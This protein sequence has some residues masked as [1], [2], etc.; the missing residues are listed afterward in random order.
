MEDGGWRM[1]NRDRRIE[2]EVKMMK[3]AKYEK[4]KA[5]SEIFEY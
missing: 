3:Q 4:R 5:K 2:I 1:E